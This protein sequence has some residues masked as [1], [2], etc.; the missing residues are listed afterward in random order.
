MHVLLRLLSNAAALWVATR[1]VPGITHTGDGV[2]LFGVALVFG[3]LN[4]AIKPILFLLS[5]PFLIITLGLFTFVLNAVMLLLTSA[6]SDA[7]GLG[8][9]VD[10]FWAAFFGGLVVSVVS[11]V[12]SL[13]VASNH[14]GG[15][16]KIDRRDRKDRQDRQ[17]W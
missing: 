16:K 2:T 14:Q 11:F 9:T 15:G 6:A 7:L 12:L 17:D 5:L 8:F 13:F 10:G 4:V 3:V 1:L